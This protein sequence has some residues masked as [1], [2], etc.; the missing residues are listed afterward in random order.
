VGTLPAGR[1]HLSFTGDKEKIEAA[2]HTQIH[3][4]N[5]SGEQHYA[6]VSG[7]MIPAALKS[8][9]GLATMPVPRHRPTRFIVAQVNTP[10]MLV[11]PTLRRCTTSCRSTSNASPAPE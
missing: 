4:S 1:A 11:P 6:N 10:A 7:P 5:V 9:I 8:M 2:F 3:L